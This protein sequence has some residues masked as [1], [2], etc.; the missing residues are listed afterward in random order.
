MTKIEDY[1]REASIVFTIFVVEQRFVVG[2]GNEYFKSYQGT[3]NFISTEE[4]IKKNIN[5]L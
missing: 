1:F 5:N 4:S 2:Q 3:A